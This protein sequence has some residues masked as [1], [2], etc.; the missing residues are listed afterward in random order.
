[1]QL[2]SAQ[3]K[4]EDLA[5]ARLSPSPNGLP[6]V[7]AATSFGFSVVQ[8]DVTIVNVAL[9]R[10]KE[11]L[12]A[13][14]A[15]LQWVVDAYTLV[16]A[17]LLLSAGVVGD[18]IGARRAYLSGFGVFLLASAAC[19]LASDSAFLIAARALQGAG[20]A[21]LLPNS[22]SLLN[23]A[24]GG[25]DR[26]RAR[27]VGFWTAAGGVAIAFGPIL[28]GLLQASTGWRSIFFVN[29]PV[30]LVGIALT[31]RHVPPSEANREQRGLDPVGQVLAVATL[32]A[33][34]A[35]LIEVGP[36]GHTH[37][38]VWG[39]FGVALVGGA[40]FIHVER[41][42]RSPML[43]LHLFRIPNFSPAVVFGVGINFAYYGVIFVLS[44]Y[45]QQVRH[46]SPLEAGLAYL[47]LT[48]TF[49]V[50]NIA[51]GWMAARVGPRA[52]MVIGAWIGALGFALLH[53][54]DEQSGYLA[55]LPAFVLIPSGIGLAVPA[56]TSA[57]L[58][59]VDRRWAGTASAISTAARQAG[60]AIGVASFGALV[61]HG[62]HRIV[63][64]L[65]ATASISVVLLGSASVIAWLGVRKRAVSSA[66]A[67]P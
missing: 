5:R 27:A 14:V 12:G 61:S 4:S 44:L 62:P 9:P 10:I 11:D 39:G 32:T 22:L 30:G 59:S 3:E 40:L 34:T 47:P 37:P 54:L 35:G 33:L 20:A 26:Q 19:G 57:V 50:S 53:L 31:L 8:L 46:Y 63:S 65:H 1:M 49:V 23:H 13:T 56:M 48:G 16:F 43:P 55:M 25:D 67:K 28:G 51:S 66:A 2:G 45:L 42:A 60:G 6:W 38:L 17:V 7:I 41:S 15:G 24:A 29:L 21:L 52:P 18:R 58:A 36:L 64:G